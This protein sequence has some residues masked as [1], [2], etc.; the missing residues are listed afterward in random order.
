LERDSRVEKGCGGGGGDDR[1]DQ[2]EGGATCHRSFLDE[3]PS[4]S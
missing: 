2:L 1:T 4:L 3:Y